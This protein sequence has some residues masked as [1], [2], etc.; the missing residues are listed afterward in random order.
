MRLDDI[1][2]LDRD[3]FAS[4]V[5]HE[6]FTYLRAHHPVF[7]HPEPNGPGF[8][9]FSKHADVRAV[10][11][12]PATYSSDQDRGGV[13]PLEEPETPDAI[14]GF[15]ILLAMDPPEGRHHDRVA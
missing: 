15:K 2:L 5:P 9:V 6:W 12:D 1:N 11:R 7:R 3:V 13:T 8:W 10:S 4:G 14:A